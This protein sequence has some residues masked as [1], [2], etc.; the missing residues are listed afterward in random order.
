MKF[1]RPESPQQKNIT[2]ILDTS[3]NSN[4]NSPLVF[5]KQ[6]SNFIRKK[7]STIS[8]SNL[9]KKSNTSRKSMLKSCETEIGNFYQSMKKKNMPVGMFNI[10]D[11]QLNEEQLFD[12][13]LFI[14]GKQNKSNYE[15]QMVTLY[16]NTIPKFVNLMKRSSNFEEK[17]FYLL[18][19]RVACNMSYQKVEKDT[20]LFRTGDYGDRVYIVLEG[21]IWIIIAKDTRVKMSEEEYLKYLLKLRK[22]NETSLLSLCL[23]LNRYIYHFTMED[24]EKFVK[25]YS[26]K[27]LAGEKLPVTVHENGKFNRQLTLRSS[28]IK[29]LIG[30]LKI[31]DFEEIPVSE[32]QIDAE[33]YIDRLDFTS[34]YTEEARSKFPELTIFQYHKIVKV[35]K[36]D[37][38]GEMCLE[39]SEHKRT[40]S[41]ITSTDCHLGTLT[42]NIYNESIKEANDKIK[43][44]NIGFLIS[45]PIFLN[46][47]RNNFEHFLFNLFV[48]V[49]ISRGEMLFKENTQADFV[50][51]IKEGEFD[52]STKKS[53][54][55]INKLI[56]NSGGKISKVSLREEEQI[57]DKS[58]NPSAKNFYSQKRLIRIA[59]LKENECVGLDDF[60]YNGNYFCS[61]KC[62]SSK[63]EAFSINKKFIDQIIQ[64][65]L[66][67]RYSLHDTDQH[68]F[69]ENLKQFINLK[70]KIMAE[71]LLNVR[72]TQILNFRNREKSFNFM[73]N[74]KTQQ[75]LKEEKEQS[76]VTGVKINM[77][78]L[79]KMSNVHKTVEEDTGF[80]TNKTNYLYSFKKL[81]SDIRFPKKQNISLSVLNQFP[82][83][84]TDLRQKSK[85]N[86]SRNKSVKYSE[87]RILTT[88][89]DSNFQ[90][91]SLNN[92]KRFTQN[93]TNILSKTTKLDISSLA[94]SPSKNF[95]TYKKQSSLKLGLYKDQNQNTEE[96]PEKFIRGGSKKETRISRCVKFNKNSNI[97]NL[98]QKK[99][100]K[101]DFQNEI[102]LCQTIS[103]NSNKIKSIKG[104]I[105]DKAYETI[106]YFNSTTIPTIPNEGTITSQSTSG[107]IIDCLVIDKLFES[108]DKFKIGV[109]CESN[110]K[111][112]IEDFNQIIKN[113][114]SISNDKLT[115]FTKKNNIVKSRAKIFC[116]KIFCK[117]IKTEENKILD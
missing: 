106:S 58:S 15:I 91:E 108:F 18:M 14:I 45:H 111:K 100:T 52:V 66:K 51:F 53:L 31:E 32:T 36:G 113:K 29:S 54:S 80:N 19:N 57:F 47:S 8:V 30:G 9:D 16:L 83:F 69:Q 103:G 117:R 25:N 41:V 38:F 114:N 72:S 26:S 63:G 65:E 44:Q 96:I 33:E 71:R 90:L 104:E 105:L 76:E 94:V 46:Y 35:S 13:F 39:S 116:N 97:E 115:F 5:L 42:E 79:R 95:L 67:E 12:L 92:F 82:N 84:N 88:E 68:S 27:L 4:L 10:K 64:Y 107:N 73:E 101:R 40:A 55:S 87:I 99:L 78:M 22:Y 93:S 74:R 34:K 48:R 109:N 21:E 3:I 7:S 24:F 70:K 49:N 23:H 81:I 50:Y 86:K 6:R 28:Q 2:P 75:I 89:N 37:T 61:V 43:R 102:T 62:S 112:K 56:Q 11:L 110:K 17:N 1:E 59:L 98:K 85:D 20:L 77:Q 60:T